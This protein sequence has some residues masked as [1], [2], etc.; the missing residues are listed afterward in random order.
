MSDIQFSSHLCSLGVAK[1]PSSS[2]WDVRFS[3]LI[4]REG[5]SR[6]AQSASQKGRKWMTTAGE[7]SD[8]TAWTLTTKLNNNGT[9]RK[10]L[11]PLKTTTHK[12]LRLGV[13]NSPFYGRLVKDPR[14]GEVYSWLERMH[15]IPE[16]NAVKKKRKKNTHT[17]IVVG[18]LTC[19]FFEGC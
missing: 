13:G 15:F 14:T 9:Q 1:W 16:D 4:K 7:A 5:C 11:D 17:H 2:Q 8:C 6:E 10:L 19:L 3:S 12:L 18:V